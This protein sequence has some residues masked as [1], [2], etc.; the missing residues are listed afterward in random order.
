M[1]KKEKYIVLNIEYQ[2]VQHVPKESILE[3]LQSL[4]TMPRIDKEKVYEDIVNNNP[5]NLPKFKAETYYLNFFKY[6][7]KENEL[8][9]IQDFNSDSYYYIQNN[10]VFKT[11]RFEAQN[12]FYQEIADKTKQTHEYTHD[13][14]IDKLHTYETIFLAKYSKHLS[15]LDEFIDENRFLFDT[16]LEEKNKTKEKVKLKMK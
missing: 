6:G 9:V 3:F 8:I 10:Q 7:E 12:K 15:S 16:V 14:L 13:T 11:D 5:I 4:N 1:E 2:E